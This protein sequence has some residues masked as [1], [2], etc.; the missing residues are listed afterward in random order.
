MSAAAPTVVDVAIVGG[1]LVGASLALALCGTDKRIALIEAIAPDAAAQPSFDDRTSALGNGSRRIFETLGVWPHLA[2]QAGAVREIHV[3]EAGRIGGARLSAAEQGLEALGFVVSNRRIGAALWKQLAAHP[4]LQIRCPARVREVRLETE[5]V[6]LVVETQLSADTS[7]SVPEP[8][9]A[10]LVVA[11]DGAQSLVRAAAG[12]SAVVEDYQQVALVVHLSTDRPATGIAYER[13]TP[14]GPLA[15]LP[16]VD[17]RYTVV[18][19]LSPERVTQLLALDDV[20]FVEELQRSFGWR[21]GRVQQVGARA[22]YPLRLSRAAS[23]AGQRAVLVGNA[24]QA[25]HPVAGQGFNLGLR[26]AA[27]LAEIIAGAS[28]PGAPAVLESFEQRRGADRRGMIGFTDGLVKLF[29]NDSSAVAAAR[30]LGLL[31]FDVT[32]GAKRALSR[33][34]WGFGH[35]VPRLMRGLPVA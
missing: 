8:M 5:A 11:A 33:L 19:T 29:A 22:S 13:F 16:L 3:S 10:R 4:Q 25:L 20:A 1:G 28:D 15:V 12:I 2:A 23:L 27:L 26:D 32:P 14:T 9:A 30:N 24:A 17:G 18:W 21:I 31:L 34:S 35:D 7:N 6:Q